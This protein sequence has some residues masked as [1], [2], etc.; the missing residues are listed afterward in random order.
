M[1]N[2]TWN[3]QL[4]QRSRIITLFVLIGFLILVFWMNNNYPLLDDNDPRLWDAIAVT[5][6]VSSIS[7]I[8]WLGLKRRKQLPETRTKLWRWAL[9]MILLCLLFSFSISCLMVGIFI[10]L[11]GVLDREPAKSQEFT[12]IAK[13]DGG[14]RIP[15]EFILGSDSTIPSARIE[16]SVASYNKAAVGDHIILTIKPG[17][18]GAP[19]I[20]SRNYQ[21]HPLNLLFLPK[22]N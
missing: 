6:G 8:I 18:F 15:Y 4:S 21:R 12:I 20:S 1:S 2:R 11:N 17:F 10:G 19:W 16:V 3:K 22:T 14:S 9:A 13:H 5:F 7:G